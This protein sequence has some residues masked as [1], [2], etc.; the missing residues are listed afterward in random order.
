[1]S[2]NNEYQL[3]NILCDFKL[4]LYRTIFFIQ[5]SILYRKRRQNREVEKNTYLYLIP[6]IIATRG[7]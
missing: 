5:R 4:I 7:T 1:M 3:I 6:N 2:E